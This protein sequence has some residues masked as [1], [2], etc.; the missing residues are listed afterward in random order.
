MQKR[1]RFVSKTRVIPPFTKRALDANTFVRTND[2]H[3]RLI[4]PPNGLT[5]AIPSPVR[6]LG[7]RGN[8][9]FLVFL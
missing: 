9:A 8:G 6:S 3:P 7:I 1:S 4:L 5:V 2:R